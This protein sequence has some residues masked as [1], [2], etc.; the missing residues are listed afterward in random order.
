MTSTV[1]EPQLLV[2]VYKVVAAGA[3][4]GVNI[5]PEKIKPLM[6]DQ[7]PL[8]PADADSCTGVPV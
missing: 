8:P 4:S 7:L 3:A 5:F 6:G 2:K 1:S